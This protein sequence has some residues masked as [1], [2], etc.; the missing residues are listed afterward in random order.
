MRLSI[1]ISTILCVGV[2]TVTLASPTWEEQ[3]ENW[4]TIGEPQ[5]AIQIADSVLNSDATAE[6]Q[7]EALLLKARCFKSMQKPVKALDNYKRAIQVE[8]EDEA[9]I[10]G[11][12]YYYLG[13]FYLDQK[14]PKEALV[15]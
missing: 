6:D 4:R 15:Y 8:V 14:S 11:L 1:F 9:P 10:N 7:A 12:R 2:H 5:N 13:V 3:A